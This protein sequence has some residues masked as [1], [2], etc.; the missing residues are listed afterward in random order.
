MINYYSDYPSFLLAF[1]MFVLFKL[2]T[3]FLHNFHI[4]SY[5]LSGSYL[6]FYILTLQSLTL[7]CTDSFSPNEISSFRTWNFGV[8]MF[9]R[10]LR[11]YQSIV[12]KNAIVWVLDISISGPVA[13][14]ECILSSSYIP[15]RYDECDLHMRFLI[16]LLQCKSCEWLGNSKVKLCL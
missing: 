10:R 13:T 8:L 4:K 6:I 2:W 12:F 16:K 11:S 9:S 7:V 5:F 15:L 1:D 14:T 3:W